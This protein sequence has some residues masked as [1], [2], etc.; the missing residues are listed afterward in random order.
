MGF[1]F[2]LGDMNCVRQAQASDLEAVFGLCVGF[3]T[4]FVP[5]RA[6][7]ERAFRS[8]IE[9]T[10]ARMLVAAVDDRV[11]GYLLGFEH[12]TLFANGPVALVE[13]LA[14]E[15]EFRRRGVARG[16][17]AVF[18]SWAIER[19][20]RYVSVATRRAAGFYEAIGYEGSAEFYRKL[21]GPATQESSS[22]W[23][24]CGA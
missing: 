23:T 24:P 15:D 6:A 19:Q 16:L 9:A 20:C 17:I 10:E 11:V 12:Q 18:E 22:D 3:A 21:L 13:E 7:F 4:S 8:V 5:E 2:R 14:V 1:R